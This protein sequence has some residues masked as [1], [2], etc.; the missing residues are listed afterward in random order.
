[1][2]KLVLTKLIPNL[3]TLITRGSYCRLLSTSTSSS[4]SPHDTDKTKILKDTFGR[5]HDYLRIS[6]SERCNLRCLYCMPEEGVQLTPNDKLLSTDEVIRLATLFVKCFGIQKIRL[7]GGEPLIRSDIVEIMTRLNKLKT[8]G[9]KKIGMTTNGI[10]FARHCES[11][12]KSGLDSVNISLDTLRSDRFEHITRR[13]GL[14]QVLKSIELALNSGFDT[15]KL[16]C[17]PMKS[18]NDDEIEDFVQLTKNTNLEVRF[19]EYMPFD[20]NRWNLDK[21][22]TFRELLKRIQS[23][24]PGLY[25]LKPSSLNETA[26]C[27]KVDGF[28]GTIGFISS[29]TNP[30]CGTCNRIRLTADGNLKEEV[31]LKD[32]IRNGNT[33]D[34]LKQIMVDAIQKK[35]K[36][37]AGAVNIAKNVNRPMILI[38][39]Q[40]VSWILQ[41]IETNQLTHID[42]KSGKASMV[43]IECKQATKR[44]AVARGTIHLGN[45]ILKAIESNS[46]TKGDVLTVAKLAAVMATKQTGHLIPLCH[47]IQLDQVDI[48]FEINNEKGEIIIESNVIATHKTGVEMEALIAVSIA[49]LTIYDMCK[50][51]HKEI[52]IGNIKLV[53]KL[54]GKTNFALNDKP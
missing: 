53:K 28:M 39:G 30:F 54:G 40:F 15:V 45:D 31:S 42:Q 36:Q 25:Q 29:M 4:S 44:E 5:K 9:L 6:L 50:S 41:S 32:A 43:N 35:K 24:F 17:V 7:T 10:V 11:L 22:V 47:T 13:R 23:R 49:A 37:H 1:M 27:Y 21:M 51:M 52:T 16:N 38:G 18:V 48:C 33:D 14:V 34:Q 12:R 20:G 19:I 8:I 46:V 2:N 3:K 26:R